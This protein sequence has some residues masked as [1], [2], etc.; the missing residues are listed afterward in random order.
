MIEVIRH[1]YKLSGWWDQPDLGANVYLVVDGGK[2]TLID[3]GYAH[4]FR[5][6]LG[7]IHRMGFLPSCVRHIIVTHHHP[8]HVGGLAALKQTTGAAVVAHADDVP[9]IEGALPQPG[10]CRPGWL[11]SASAPLVPLLRTAPV[12]VDIVVKGGEELP[13]AGGIR[14]LHTPGHTPGS[15]CVFL[16]QRGL[17]MTGDLLAQRLGIRLPA[18]SFT[19][20]VGQ[21]QDSVRKLAEEDFETACFGHGSPLVKNAS[22]RVAEYARRLDHKKP[23]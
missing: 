1:V 22:K 7:R 14:V 5:L 3:T 12:K 13:V 20:D 21:V 11:R 18:L 17:V 8:D 2:L 16:R 6:I 23:F 9:Y 10:P 15:I 4:N 19:V